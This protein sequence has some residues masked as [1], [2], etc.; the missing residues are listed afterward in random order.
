MADIDRRP[1]DA[2]VTESMVGSS[3][4]ESSVSW[5]E[6]ETMLYALGIGAGLGDPQR[7]LGLLATVSPRSIRPV[8]GLVK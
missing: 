1:Y 8:S 7:D 6:Q 5:S 4:G 2:R 3:S